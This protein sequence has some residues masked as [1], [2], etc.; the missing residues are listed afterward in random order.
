[1]LEV[2]YN[3]SVIS[4]TYRSNL[5]R[6]WYSGVHLFFGDN[7]NAFENRVQMEKR[8]SKNQLNFVWSKIEMAISETF[9]NV[10]CC[11]NGIVWLFV[12]PDF[13][14]QILDCFK[15]NGIPISGLE[16]DWH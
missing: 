10:K 2:F 3:F 5:P 12:K 6:T 8:K 7:I 16:M 15:N 4:G 11:V 13:Q 1:M 14:K 9:F